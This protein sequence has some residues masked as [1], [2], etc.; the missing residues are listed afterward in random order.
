MCILD[1]LVVHS[2]LCG[3][4]SILDISVSPHA[5]ACFSSAQVFLLFQGKADPFISITSQDPKTNCTQ[6]YES[7]G[8]ETPSLSTF[9]G[10]NAAGCKFAKLAAGGTAYFLLV[11]MVTG[12]YF[13]VGHTSDD[14]VNCVSNFLRN[15]PS[16]QAL[17]LSRQISL[18]FSSEGNRF[19][20]EAYSD[21]FFTSA[22]E[23]HA[24]GS[25][26]S[27]AEI[28]LQRDWSYRSFF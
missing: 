14:M 18:T 9:L 3:L 12:K 17:F 19:R 6:I 11:V 13:E 28:E 7:L 16:G 2:A 23:H 1:C 5:Q 25:S 20:T 8:F 10:W 26:F 4:A 24:S 27:R 22:S 21:T 15:P